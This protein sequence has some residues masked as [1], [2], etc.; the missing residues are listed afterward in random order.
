MY[1]RHIKLIKFKLNTIHHLVSKPAL[2]L[3]SISTIQCSRVIFLNDSFSFN[4]HL[5]SCYS[6]RHLI[7]F[8]KYLSLHPT[9]IT[10]AQIT[11]RFH[12]GKIVL[13]VLSLA[14]NLVCSSFCRLRGSCSKVNVGIFLPDL[15]FYKGFPL[16][17]GYMLFKILHLK[18]WLISQCNSG[19]IMKQSSVLKTFIVG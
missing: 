4:T 7:T 3:L 14:L 10:L 13:S 11:I 12:W 17:I 16:L 6:Q 2:T 1:P 19:L 8:S 18:F 5:Y 9:T 15:K